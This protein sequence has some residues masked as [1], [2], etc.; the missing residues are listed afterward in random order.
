M[1][2]DLA[3]TFGVDLRGLEVVSLQPEDVTEDVVELLKRSVEW[4]NGDLDVG[5]LLRAHAKGT[6]QMFGGMRGSAVEAVMV[7]E[8]VQYPKKKVLVVLAL[9]GKA[10]EFTPFLAFIEHWAQLNGATEIEAFCRKVMVRYTRRF[11]FREV[12]SVVRKTIERGT[13]Q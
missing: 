11:G 7:T 6:M 5:D 1:R 4:A 13:L 3:A 9:A 12:R 8:F 2:V 10:R